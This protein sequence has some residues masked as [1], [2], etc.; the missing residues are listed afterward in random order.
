VQKPK[1]AIF[2]D[3]LDLSTAADQKT[4]IKQQLTEGIDRM[5]LEGYRK[6]EDELKS[7]RNKKVRRYDESQN[8]RL[9]SWLEVDTLVKSMAEDILESLNP[10]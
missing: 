5:K 1:F 6:R 10:D 8:E 7:I 4:K 9:D 3:A 2:S